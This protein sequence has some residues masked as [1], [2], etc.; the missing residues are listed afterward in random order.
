MPYLP[1][2]ILTYLRRD[3]LTLSRAVENWRGLTAE[4]RATLHRL[5]P[6]PNPFKEN[7]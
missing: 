3:G 4:Q 2:R 5:V 6:A 1:H 7:Q